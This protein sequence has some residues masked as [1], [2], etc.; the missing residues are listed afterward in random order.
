MIVR[1]THRQFIFPFKSTFSRNRVKVK[2]NARGMFVADNTDYQ[3]G[4]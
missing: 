3:G 4:P 2:R 1:L